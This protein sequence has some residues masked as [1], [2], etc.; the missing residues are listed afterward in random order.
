[1]KKTIK[2]KTMDIVERN[3]EEVYSRLYI[4]EIKDVL[5]TSY[6]FVSD[7]VVFHNNSRLALRKFKSLFIDRV[8]DHSFLK[9][10]HTPSGYS[11]ELDIPNVDSF[12]FNGLE[13]LELITLG[14][15]ANYVELDERMRRQISPSFPKAPLSFRVEGT[16]V[17]LY[18]SKR[19]SSLLNT[20]KDKNM[21]IMMFPFSIKNKGFDVFEETDI[22]DDE[23]FDSMLELV[24]TNITKDLKTELRR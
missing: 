23:N 7:S 8:E 12:N 6:D 11:I 3:I 1:M 22:Y 21:D 13:I 17:Y 4:P 24:H 15:P 2:K 14:V 18:D 19:Y 20:L 16:T 5:E 9:V 10:E